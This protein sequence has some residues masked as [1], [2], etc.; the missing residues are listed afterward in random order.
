MR[1]KKK[2][3]KT[4]SDSEGLSG[5]MERE[6]RSGTGFR[7]TAGRWLPWA[8]VVRSRIPWSRAERRACLLLQT[9]QD[10]STVILRP[11]CVLST[12]PAVRSPGFS[13]HP[14]FTDGETEAWGGSVTWPA[15]G[16]LTARLLEG[17]EMPSPI[18]CCLLQKPLHATQPHHIGLFTLNFRTTQLPNQMSS[19][20]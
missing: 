18:Q 3:E 15:S 20:I 5:K 6:S 17:A 1:K 14:P 10:Q 9:Q 16:C 7:M 2:I 19:C 13:Q 12:V 4:R 11:C 8:W